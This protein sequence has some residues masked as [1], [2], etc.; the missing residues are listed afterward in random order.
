MFDTVF[1][2]P[3]H[4]LVVHATVVVVPTAAAAVLL[5]A[6]WP[7]FR[8][9]AGWGPLALAAAAAAVTPLST[10]SGES[11]DGRVPAT[12]LV[13]AHARLGDQLVPWVL[14]LLVASAV[15]TWLWRRGRR[16]EVRPGTPTWLPAAAAALCVVAALGTS[17]QV[18]RIGHS[19][20]EAAWSD[21]ATATPTGG[22]GDG[23]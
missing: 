14:G 22:G 7:R 9:W 18:V 5:A 8:E 6:V 4:P 16:T 21:V 10:Q 12:A 2:L 15:T 11:L 17:V 3:L 19:G 13:E 20:A 23:D 1:G